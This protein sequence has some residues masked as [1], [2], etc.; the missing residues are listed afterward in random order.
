VAAWISSRQLLQSAIC[1][2]TSQG[3]AASN[4]KAKCSVSDT[5]SSKTRPERVHGLPGALP[6]S[7]THPYVPAA[8]PT[9][10]QVRW[11]SHTEGSS[12]RPSGHQPPALHQRNLPMAQPSVPTH[13]RTQDPSQTP[14]IQ[15]TQPPLLYPLRKHEMPKT[16]ALC[17][18]W[19]R[20][21]AG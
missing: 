20:S 21:H 13:T 6:L 8:L 18:V 19:G 1:N 5:V 12:G 2:R 14:G 9:E 15:Q 4:R 3:T 10:V 11:R 16:V 7:G 17:P